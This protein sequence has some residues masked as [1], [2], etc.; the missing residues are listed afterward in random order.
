MEQIN[1][2]DLH[3]DD[4]SKLHFELYD[5]GSYL[6]KNQK[7]ASV[8]HRHSYYQLIWFKTAGR[9]FVD[10]EVIDHPQNS[11]F[12]ISRNQIHHFCTESPNQGYLFHFNDF[13]I[14][15]AGAGLMERFSTTIFNTIG[16]GH[17]VLSAEEAQ[18]M[19]QLTTLI[20]SEVLNKGANYEQQV[21][22]FFQAMLFQIE[23]LLEKDVNLDIGTDPDFKLAADFKKLILDRIDTFLTI[24]DY[25]KALGTNS[26]KLT[27]VSKTFLMSTPAA[28][29]KESRLLEAK[30]MLSN[31][32]LSIKEIAYSLG[33][34]DPT[35]FT[36]YFKRGTELTPREF[37]KAYL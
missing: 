22:H 11:I 18:K 3:K 7:P 34:E 17:L 14:N 10:Y 19:E 35:Y 28:V 13:F 15:R 21:F 16:K 32:N 30:R 36:K 12:F 4:Y 24:Q 5:A 9:H 6:G 31:Q 27:S 26:K 20:S 2:Y 37:Q 23:R 25:A 1:R 29:I 33:F 8:P